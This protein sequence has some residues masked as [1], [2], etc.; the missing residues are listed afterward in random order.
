M[1][2]VDVIAQASVEANNLNV[3]LTVPVKYRYAI[4][5]DFHNRW[6][7]RTRRFLL[8][9]HQFN[10]L[11]DLNPHFQQRDMLIALE[12]GTQEAIAFVNERG[13][14]IPASS[15]D[16]VAG[17]G[18][19]ETLDWLEQQ[20]QRATE[21]AI[22]Y[23]AW[24][25]K[26]NNIIWLQQRG[27]LPTTDAMVAAAQGGHVS[28]LEHL[29]QGGL[30]ADKRA[31]VAAAKYGHLDAL[32]WLYSRGVKFDSRLL[33]FSVASGREDISD[34]LRSLPDLEVKLNDEVS[35]WAAWYGNLPAVQQYY[36]P[37]FLDSAL[38]NAIERGH[39]EI[40]I[41]LLKHK[42]PNAD[43]LE[44]AAELGHGD[45]V[46]V[47]IDREP[48]PSMEQAIIKAIKNGH[49]D[50]ANIL[51]EHVQPNS[52]ILSAAVR[53]R[54]RELEERLL[55]DGVMVDE[56]VLAAYISTGRMS[57][58]LHELDQDTLTE[59]VPVAAKYGQLKVVKNLM[60]LGGKAD[61]GALQLAAEKGHLEVVMWL[62]EQSNF[63]H[64]DIDEALERAIRRGYRNVVK[65][66]IGKL[67]D[68]PSDDG[69]SDDEVEVNHLEIAQLVMNE[70]NIHTIVENSITCNYKCIVEYAVE[71]GYSLRGRDADL[72][73]MGGC[74]AIL[75]YV[76]QHSNERCSLFAYKY[77]EKL[78][79]TSVVNYLRRRGYNREQDMW[80]DC[81][82]YRYV[83][84]SNSPGLPDE[85]VVNVDLNDGT[86][87]CT[88]LSS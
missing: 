32:K 76:Y 33:I 75:D 10:V 70:Q 4:A 24:H 79:H 18:D 81:S 45:I 5:Q 53:Y 69:P 20:G 7:K 65:F 25:G 19:I 9:Q 59:L 84:P 11:N 48:K 14:A 87:V 63:D 78:S 39:T 34:F 38:T 47:I 43:E 80:L 28:V 13:V 37:R 88:R 41:E 27:V 68:G 17:T 2:P 8:R 16:V 51:L 72:A 44:L 82:Y 22:T 35:S 61:S 62:I 55:Q 12:I 77:A 31:P 3:I 52:Q 86:Y 54:F 30:L 83:P 36:K 74:L 58:R 15:L 64:D 60:Q 21:V 50:V 23:A 29:T 1:L 40:V 67:S 73:A 26:L 42:S 85:S 6:P 71:M 56:Q 66:L 57:D 49:Y 46:R